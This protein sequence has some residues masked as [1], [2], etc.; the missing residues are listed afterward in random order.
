[1]HPRPAA[2]EVPATA[3]FLAAPDLLYEAVWQASEAARVVAGDSSAPQPHTVVKP[4]ALRR[5]DGLLLDAAL[6][7]AAL[8]ALS[9]HDQLCVDALSLQR[10]CAGRGVASAVAA[11]ATHGL[12]LLR[13]LLPSASTG[14]GIRLVT[15]GASPASGSLGGEAVA[16]VS[17]A[18]AGAAM[19]AIMRVAATENPGMRVRVLDAALAGPRAVEQDG[20]QVSSASLA[21]SFGI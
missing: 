10:E 21:H 18:A 13:R 15:R 19:A 4:R 2:A 8:P 14:A 3:P 12:E 16:F 6:Y 20:S 9:A 5:R 11:G 7:T 17:A 1:M